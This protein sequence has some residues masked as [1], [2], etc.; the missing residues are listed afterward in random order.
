MYKHKLYESPNTRRSIIHS[1]MSALNGAPQGGGSQSERAADFC[2]SVASAFNLS[3]EDAGKYKTACAFYDIGKIAVDQA[4]L[5]KKEALTPEE[6]EAV[7]RHAEIGY[8]ILNA[9]PEFAEIADYALYHHERWDGTGYPRGL[10]GAEIPYLA[11]ILAVVDA[12][13]AMTSDRPYRKAF[14]VEAA[15]SELIRCAGTQFEP[16]TARIFVEKILARQWGKA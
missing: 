2:W 11:R 16:E 13:G 10:K 12:F 15:A 14:S 3:D 5:N 9:I 7:K 6:W 4:T 8:R 1:I